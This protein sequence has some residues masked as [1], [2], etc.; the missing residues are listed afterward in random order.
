MDIFK[1]QNKLLHV[2]SEVSKFIKFFILSA[3][4]CTYLVC[5]KNPSF[6]KDGIIENGNGFSK[7]YINVTYRMYLV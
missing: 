4:F 1:C 5:G 7:N 2:I 6:P 3:P